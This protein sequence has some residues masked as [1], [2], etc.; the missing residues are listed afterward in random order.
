[1]RA[2]YKGE[3]CGSREAGQKVRVE[4]QGVKLREAGAE[5]KALMC[6]Q[7]QGTWG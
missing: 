4:Q 2:Q 6:Q 7:G 5:D 1:M 3:A